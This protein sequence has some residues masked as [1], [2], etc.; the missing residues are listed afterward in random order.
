[1]TF[2]SANSNTL[3]ATTTLA[4]NLV[5]HVRAYG[6]VAV[7]FSGGVD[8]AVVAKAAVEALGDKTVAVTA[9]S[10]SL[11]NSELEIARREATSIGIRHVEVE[12]NEFDRPEYRANAGNRCFF[13]KDTLYRMTA[14]KL[15]ELDVSGIIN[16]ANTDDLGDHRPGM[17]AAEE[18]HVRSP[19]IE[20]GINKSQVRQLAQFWNLS[21]AEK[22]ASPCLSSRIAYGVEVTEERVRR[23]ELAEAFIRDQTGLKELRVRCEANE[24]A[25][26]EVPVESLS[27][28]ASGDLRGAVATRLNALGF[29][30]VTLDLDGFRSGSLNDALPVVRLGGRTKK[31]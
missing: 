4:Q 1:M 20:L 3:D 28:F 15:S 9:V 22:P 7:A 24:L 29:R 23:I 30:R 19:L 5:E 21:V 18:H 14:L 16:G 10:H 2:T 13:C 31:N 8:S 26:I 27:Q 6:P 11:A 25:R 17:T 12:T